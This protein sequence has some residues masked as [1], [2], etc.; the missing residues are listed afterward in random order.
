MKSQLTLLRAHSLS[1][2]P[3]PL[4]L[5][6]QFISQLPPWT[7]PCVCCLPSCKD[8]TQTP[9]VI[10]VTHRSHDLNRR[11]RTRAEKFQLVCNLLLNSRVFVFK[12]GKRRWVCNL[13]MQASWMN[14]TFFVFKIGQSK[15]NY[16][17]CVCTS[18]PVFWWF[19]V[20]VL[21]EP[22]SAKLYRKTS[23]KFRKQ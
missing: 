10:S 7:K 12:P 14:G 21:F 1:T 20:Y 2:L 13:R 17:V 23:W 16:I 9:N 19:N 8:Y 18:E 4:Q 22:F 6:R 15:L 11:K 5:I 3:S